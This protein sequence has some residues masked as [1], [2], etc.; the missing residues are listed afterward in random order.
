MNYVSKQQGRS[1]KI[2]IENCDNPRYIGMKA[3]RKERGIIGYNYLFND[4]SK[5]A[6]LLIMK[7]LSFQSKSSYQL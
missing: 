1:A 7:L 3:L 5:N 6:I 2:N 4:L